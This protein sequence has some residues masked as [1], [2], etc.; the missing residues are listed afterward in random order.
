VRLVTFETKGGQDLPRPGIVRGEQVIDLQ[1]V[2]ADRPALLGPVNPQALDSMRTLLAAGPEALAAAERIAAG[3][4]ADAAETGGGAVPLAACR[5]L[6]PV[7]D[8]EKFL[9]VGKNYRAHLEELV[10]ND[11]L[12]EW[13]D[14][15]TGFIKLNS[16]LVGQDA[17]VARPAG[18]IAFDYEPELAFV[19]GRPAFRVKRAQAMEVIAGVTLLNDLTSREIQ[20][21]EVRSGTRFWTAKNMPGFGPVGPSIITLDEIGDPNDLW[22]TCAV[23]GEQRLRFNTSDQIFKIDD[24]IEHFSRY[25]PLQPGDMFSTGAPPGCAVGRPNADELYLKPGDVVEI[26]IEGFPPLRTHIVAET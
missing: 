18:I 17:E 24:I 19:I 16:C 15:P 11:L 4:P 13:P 2:A 7:P 9:C 1:R 21:R 10:R 22:L 5:L 8:P 14:E 25:I 23:N 20:R 12:K 6:P 3:V 26:A